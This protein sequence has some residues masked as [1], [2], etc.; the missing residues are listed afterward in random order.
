MPGL[1]H[2]KA[3]QEEGMREDVFALIQKHK[4]VQV[5]P[6]CLLSQPAHVWA[7]SAS[8]ARAVL[9]AAVV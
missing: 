3:S 2:L 8:T 9:H 7:L 4:Y 1:P 6:A 5:R